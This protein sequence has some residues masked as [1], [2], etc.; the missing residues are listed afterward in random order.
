MV[1]VFE[2]DVLPLIFVYPPQCGRSLEDE[3]M[4]MS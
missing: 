4:K 3:M 1:L 2:E